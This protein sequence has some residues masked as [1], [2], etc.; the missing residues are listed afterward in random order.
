M[1]ISF[2]F[3]GRISPEKWIDRILC[4]VEEL[5]AGGY[6]NF[7]VTFIGH[8]PMVEAIRLHPLFWTHLF[9][10]GHLPNKEVLTILKNTTYTVMPSSFLET[11]WLVALESLS[12][13]VP[14]L[15]E[16]KWW[17][18]PFVIDSCLCLDET[19]NLTQRMSYLLADVAVVKYV[20]LQ[21]KALSIA[22]LYTPTCWL[23]RFWQLS[24]NC[25]KMLLVSDYMVALG[26]IENYIF[27]VR[28]LLEIQGIRVDLFWKTKKPTPV[29]RKID[30]LLSG[31]NI[32]AAYR[33]RIKLS[34]STYD[35]VW[36]HSIQRW[37]WWQ[38]VRLVG[39]KQK[40]VWCMY[41]EVGLI[42][43]FPSC[44]TSTQQLFRAQWFRGYMQEWKN[45]C[46]ALRRYMWCWVLVCAKYMY[47]KRLLYLLGKVVTVHLV[48]SAYLIPYF[49]KA[50]PR[51]A[52]IEEFPHFVSSWGNG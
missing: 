35:V 46:G 47:T 7:R 26:W 52:R 3:V 28:S 4:A 33:L 50:L 43:P 24:K 1:D 20:D 9:Y 41:H 17:L 22:S 15:A 27:E 18:I 29:S 19:H 16:K 39:K 25:K 23:D 21:Q 34:S 5:V 40:E 14:V 49:A 13:W 32:M 36:L 37:L 45:V 48:P 44:V 11:F 30:L 51:N 42:H 10:L 31:A 8:G 38:V 2:L 6:T 12:M